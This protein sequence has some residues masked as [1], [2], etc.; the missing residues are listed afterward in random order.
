MFK[1]SLIAFGTASA[2]MLAL[3]SA[4]SMQVPPPQEAPAPAPAP[5]PM[6]QPQDAMDQAAEAIAVVGCLR[7]VSDAENSFALVEAKALDI[8][9]SDATS[10]RLVPA[11]ADV[12]LADFVANRVEVSG[13]LEAGAGAPMAAA[14]P[15]GEEVTEADLAG[16]P[17]IQVTSIDALADTCEM[18]A[19]SE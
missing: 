1:R 5:A 13:T 7:A 9:Q 2:L 18:P 10:F 6:E 12:T 19:P 15:Q 17:T 14:A 3:Q 8:A 4:P 16:A 11:S